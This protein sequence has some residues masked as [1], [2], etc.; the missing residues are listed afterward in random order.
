MIPDV[1]ESC[2]SAEVEVFAF[3]DTI[4]IEARSGMEYFIQRGEQRYGPYNTEELQRYV[5]SGNIVLGD[6]AQGEGSSTWTSVLQIL[7]SFPNVAPIVTPPTDASPFGTIQLQTIPFANAGSDRAK[8]A[9]P[10]NLPWILVL[11][12]LSAVW[13]F[14][15]AN[16]ARKLVPG[17]KAL[18]LIALWPVGILAGIGIIAASNDLAIVGLALALGGSYCYL[19]GVFSIRAAMEQYYNSVEIADL[20]LSPVMTFFLQSVY[21]QYHI[22]RLHKWKQDGLLSK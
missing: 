17:N 3:S 10:P 18:L 2:D 8:V 1:A 7:E 15:Q 9:L 19:A 5:R 21:F 4:Y 6:V 11:L 12:V 22:N 13:I 14:V 20:D 16:W